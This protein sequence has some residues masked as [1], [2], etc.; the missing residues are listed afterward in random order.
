VRD[1]AA[2]QAAVSKVQ[3]ALIQLGG[4]HTEA[5]ESPILG[6]EGN[7]EFL[8]HAQFSAPRQV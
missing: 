5:I 7:R 1:E 4:Q 2:Q 8:L 6:G 3:A